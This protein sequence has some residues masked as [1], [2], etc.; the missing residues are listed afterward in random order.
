M[1]FNLTLLLVNEFHGKE[2]IGNKEIKSAVYR[3]TGRVVRL[4]EA[5]DIKRRIR[6]SGAYETIQKDGAKEFSIKVIGLKN[7]KPAYIPESPFAPL[8]KPAGAFEVMNK[9]WK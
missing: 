7:K 4:S 9:V 1:K 6:R 2:W 5:A 3:L 8:W